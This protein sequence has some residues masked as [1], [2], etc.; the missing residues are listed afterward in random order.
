VGERITFINGAKLKEIKLWGK[1]P[2][3]AVN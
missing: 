2:E 1:L 3:T